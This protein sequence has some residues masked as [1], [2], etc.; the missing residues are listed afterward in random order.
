MGCVEGK[1]SVHFMFSLLCCLGR[2]DFEFYFRFFKPVL[3]SS[4]FQMFYLL[5]TF[6]PLISLS[7]IFFLRFLISEIL[8][9]FKHFLLQIVYCK[10]FCV[11]ILD[12]A[13]VGS[14]L[15]R[16]ENTNK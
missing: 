5:K 3:L 11:T 2:F 15:P 12:R 1:Y 9:T 8:S 13:Q 7:F 6:G 16:F 4:L 14:Q 10:V